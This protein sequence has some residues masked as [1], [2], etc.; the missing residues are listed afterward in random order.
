MA[1]VTRWGC[2]MCAFEV[3]S[4]DEEETINIAR[5]HVHEAHDMEMSEDDVRDKVE[6][7]DVAD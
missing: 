5:E 3:Q 7:A 1:E 2:D 4:E 6:M